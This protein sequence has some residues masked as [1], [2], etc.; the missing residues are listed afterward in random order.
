MDIGIPELIEINAL[1]ERAALCAELGLAFVELNMNIPSSQTGTLRARDLL[2]LKRK[3][4]IYFTLHLDENLNPFDFNPKVSEAY[5]DTMKDA[6]KLA[7]EAE[8]PILNMHLSDGVYFTMPEGKIYL[9]DRYEKVYLDSVRAFR[10]DIDKTAKG[11]N[12]IIAIENTNGYRDFQRK[13]IDILLESEVFAL[14]LDIGHGACAG[15]AG[16]AD[17][18]F[19]VKRY[20]KLR[21][22]HIHDA[23]GDKCHLPLD[24]G[25]TDWRKYLAMAGYRGCRAVIETKTVAGLEKSVKILRNEKFIK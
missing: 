10:D 23:E 7:E 22:F 20:D 11:K 18:E 8:I 6:V 19:V 3:Y 16:K 2:A 21:H 1:E 25:K 5:S 17:E 12:V 24:E 9:Y 13:A 14:T 4:G 15:R